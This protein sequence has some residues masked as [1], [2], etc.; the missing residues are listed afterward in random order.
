MLYEKFDPSDSL[1]NLVK[2]YWIFENDNPE[3]VTQKIIPDGYSEIIIHYGDPYRINLQ[4]KWEVQSS[5]LFSN[6]ISK[7]FFLENTGKSGILGIKLHPA[8]FYEL[9]EKVTS[10]FTDQVVPLEGLIGSK[11]L[12]LKKIQ[13]KGLA[14]KDKV[15]IAESWLATFLNELKTQSRVRQSLQKIFETHGM[16]DM[17]VIANEIQISTRQ[18]ER[19]FKKVIGLTPKFY[20]RI[21][22]F[23]YIFEVMKDQNDSWIRTALQSGYFDQSHF[24]KNFKE[25]TGEEPS[26]YG[27]DEVNLANFF[28]KK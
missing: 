9:F 22:R 19:Q 5:M 10:T 4:G 2:E 25:F 7:Y 6:Q 27:F 23:N 16:T 26:S 1:K 11:V 12:P 8:A 28:L 21:V 15:S 17:D 24:I 13:S 3:I 18:L 20:S 14:I